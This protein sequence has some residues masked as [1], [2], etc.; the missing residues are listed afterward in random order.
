MREAVLVYKKTEE[1]NSNVTLTASAGYA[2]YL[3]TITPDDSTDTLIGHQLIVHNDSDPVH[4]IPPYSADPILR[5]A[6]H[7]E[8]YAD[9]SIDWSLTSYGGIPGTYF[10]H[11]T[12]IGVYAVA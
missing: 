5:S 4:D 3:P 6:A 9:Q 11:A 12:L 8:D 2:E 7:M 10:I 1:I